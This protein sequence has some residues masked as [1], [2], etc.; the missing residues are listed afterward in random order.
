[1]KE[2]L[3]K[4]YWMTEKVFDYAEKK[5]KLIRKFFNAKNYHAARTE[6][7]V[8]N[9]TL[10]EIKTEVTKAIKLGGKI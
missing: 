1:M 7:T 5:L 10:K 2:K 3:H 4:E 6:I 8:L 9:I